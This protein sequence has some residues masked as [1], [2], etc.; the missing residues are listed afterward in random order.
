MKK[1]TRRNLIV[2]SILLIVFIL[3]F[4]FKGMFSIVGQTTFN[5]NY[6]CDKEK[7]CTP[8]FIIG[9][10]FRFSSSLTSFNSS[11][12][13]E[14]GYY[15]PN[16]ETKEC[17]KTTFTF[18]NKE[19]EAKYGDKFILNR[20]LSIKVYPEGR[21]LYDPGRESKLKDRNVRYVFS[22]INNGFLSSKITDKEL[23]LKI[24]QDKIAKVEVFNDFANNIDGS[25]IYNCKVD[26]ALQY[27]N[28]EEKS[29]FSKGST[30][31]GFPLHTSDL[32]TISCNVIPCIEFTIPWGEKIKLCND[33]KSLVT[34]NI[35]PNID[36]EVE[37]SIKCN[38][39]IECKFGLNCIKVNDDSICTKAKLSQ[40]KSISS[41]E[42]NLLNSTLFG[43][44]GGLIIFL[45]VLAY[46][47]YIKRR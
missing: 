38:S 19:Y 29:F 16:E 5:Y 13:K 33:E 14:E 22:I 12:I 3:L 24:N 44:L 37:T 36:L 26:R 28:G 17:W 31:S 7:G 15:T 9:D 11:C 25:L 10:D 18:N 1:R 46:L 42:M 6:Y 32:G 8:D 43:I 41:I 40:Q 21:Y 35:V 20:Y 45:G 2:I 30:P 39:D 4:L 47:E 27:L 34:Y 23:L